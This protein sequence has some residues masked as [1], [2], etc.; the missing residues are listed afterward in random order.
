M[1]A[2]HN[3]L[4]KAQEMLDAHAEEQGYSRKVLSLREGR[5]YTKVVEYSS[6]L[7]ESVFCFIDN[8]NGDVLKAA[9]FRGPAKGARGNIHDANPIAGINPYGA[10]YMR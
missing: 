10:N 9:T 2:I 1:N 6:I 5:R 4:V 7:G 3:F 8:R